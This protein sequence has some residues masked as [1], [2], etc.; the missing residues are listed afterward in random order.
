MEKGKK[1]LAGEENEKQYLSLILGTRGC[2]SFWE[3]V[4]SISLAPSRSSESFRLVASCLQLCNE[5]D[6]SLK[7]WKLDFHLGNCWHF[8]VEQRKEIIEF[9]R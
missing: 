5:N 6:A 7:K 9:N 3:T 4:L 1:P 8:G 2:V